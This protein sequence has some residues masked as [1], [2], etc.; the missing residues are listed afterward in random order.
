[1]PFPCGQCL[2]CPGDSTTNGGGSDHRDAAE[3]PLGKGPRDIYIPDLRLVLGI[4]RGQPTGGI[5]VKA[6]DF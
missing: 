2:S 4:V 6:R 1:M 3:R 5:K